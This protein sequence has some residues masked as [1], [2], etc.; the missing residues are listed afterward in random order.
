MRRSQLPRKDEFRAQKSERISSWNNR[1]RKM[2]VGSFRGRQIAHMIHE[3]FLVTG[4]HESILDFTDLM[5]VSLRG[6]D[7]QGSDAR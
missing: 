7:I 2:R 1:K 3:Y 4:F 6:D 5:N